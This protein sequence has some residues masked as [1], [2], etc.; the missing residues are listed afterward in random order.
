MSS[1]ISGT[2]WA[3]RSDPEYL[4]EALVPDAH[5]SRLSGNADSI[6]S[7]ADSLSGTLSAEDRMS[8]GSP[9][10]LG[11]GGDV[12]SAPGAADLSQLIPGPRSGEL[13]PKE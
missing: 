9:E 12:R 11:G 1:E 7:I 2:L 4:L 6:S 10:T 3:A 8:P 5:I 13:L